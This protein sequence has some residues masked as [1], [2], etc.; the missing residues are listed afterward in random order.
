MALVKADNVAATAK[1]FGTLP[2]V[3]QLV[4]MI[5]L[6]ASFAIIVGVFFWAQEPGY[7]ILYS[8]I[9]EKDVLE[10]GDALQKIG[11]QYKLQGSTGIMVP[12]DKV[13]EARMKLAAQSLPKGT[14]TGYELMDKEPV[15][16]TTEF[17]QT[18]RHQRA[19]EGELARTITSVADI[20]AARVH[21]AIPKQS[22]FIRDKKPVSASIM[23]NVR[24]GRTMDEGQ[25]SAIVHLVASSVPNLD[26]D[27]V[28]IVDQKGT[29][30]NAPNRASELSLS[31]NQFDYRKKLEDY[32]IQRIESLLSPIVG[33][34]AVRAQV[35]VD[36]DFTVTEQTQEQYNPDLPA[37]RSEQTVDEQMRN[38]QGISGIPGA[39]TNQPPAGGTVDPITNAGASDASAS[40]DLPT[41][42]TKR[43]TRNY[44]LDRTISHIRLPSGSV[45]RLSVAVIVDDKQTTNEKGEV[46]RQ[47]RTEEETSRLT[48]L[49]KEAVGFNL[50]RG[51]SVSVLNTS[52]TT[53][54]PIEPMPAPSLL[55]QPWLW[56]WI[57]K[58]GVAL[59]LLIGFVMV[60]RPVLRSLAE[61]G[62]AVPQRFVELPAGASEEQIKM[63]TAASG[64]LPA[65]PNA[66][67]Y[68]NNLNAA[69]NM[70][71]QDPKRVAQVVKTWVGTDG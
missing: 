35:S 42:S 62:Q 27:H 1:G 10:I 69:K 57:K 58:I 54:P 60:V 16:G 5:G 67:N 63:L 56:E 11:I 49:I 48:S 22:A 37:I 43:S 51:D 65:L 55:D 24:S 34:G 9:P 20:E 70:V 46:L 45:R 30:L 2:I 26:A 29:L 4:L 31:N 52:F 3:R 15:F 21:L 38:G 68:D 53:P 28:T 64:Q 33:P 66:N 23:V 44:E 36:L 47:Q 18:S 14:D 50:Q 61:K 17:A 40:A 32:Y 7:R 25:V 71:S 8:D 19:L 12:A 39:L 13:H 6:A 59:L 41:S